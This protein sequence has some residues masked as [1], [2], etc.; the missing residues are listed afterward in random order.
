MTLMLNIRNPSPFSFSFT[1]P[2]REIDRMQ[3]PS[4]TK[5]TLN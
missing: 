1:D 3:F 2:Y 4:C 5:Y